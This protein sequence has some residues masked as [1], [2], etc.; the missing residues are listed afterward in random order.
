MS[1]KRIV[2]DPSLYKALMSELDY[3][4]E[5]AQAKLEQA[6]DTVT[7]YRTQ[8]AIRALRELKQIREKVNGPE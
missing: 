4:I 6:P 3:R 7:I 1:L 8:G 5:I 2:N